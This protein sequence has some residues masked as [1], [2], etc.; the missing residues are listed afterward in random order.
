MSIRTVIADDERPARR[1][2][3]E[4]LEREADMELVAEARDGAEAVEAVLERKPDLLFLDVQ[5]PERDG[6]EVLRELGPGETPVTVFVT[7]YDRY[8]LKAFEARA[9][10]YLLKPFSDERFEAA[11]A[12]ARRYLDER[13]HPEFQDK[14]SD[15]IGSEPPLDRIVLKSAG[16]V[17]FLKVD[18]IEW[19]E[20]AGV[21]VDL[22][23][24]S[25]TH[26]YRSTIGR[27]T[28][29]LDPKR[30]VRIHRSATVN[31]ARIQSLRPL[32]HGEHAVLLH[33]GKELKLSRSYRRELEA[34]LGQPL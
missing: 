28:E 26:L 19:I 15:L 3:A 34:W 29:R 25:K 27:L 22:H 24:A 32:G 23:T 5:M 16:R 9:F 11:L 7:A 30:F 13:R 21:Y 33:S 20:A 17:T 14:V 8:A 6:F 2:L 1:R 10:D 4:L 12:H 31:T 18:D